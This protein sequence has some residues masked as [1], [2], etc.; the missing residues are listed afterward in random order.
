MEAMLKV[1]PPDAESI[2]GIMDGIMRIVEAPCGDAVKLEA[3]RT[4]GTHVG[5]PTSISNC[6]FSQVNREPEPEKSEPRSDSTTPAEE[7]MADLK[8]RIL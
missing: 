1:T 7:V 8:S 5:A 6:T 4:L 2:Q 3:L